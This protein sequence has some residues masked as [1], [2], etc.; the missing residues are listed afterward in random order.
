MSTGWLSN[1][2]STIKTKQKQDQEARDVIYGVVFRQVCADPTSLLL[3]NTLVQTVKQDHCSCD[4][5]E[6]Q[7]WFK[8]EYN[9]KTK[10]PT[11]AGLKN[12]FTV[13]SVAEPELII[14]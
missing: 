6:A 3:Q 7:K 5:P 14:L 8:L 9:S 11:K 12:D 10:T 1:A 4:V 2:Q 13:K